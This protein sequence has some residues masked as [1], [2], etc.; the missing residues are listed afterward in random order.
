[1]NP[2]YCSIRRNILFGLLWLSGWI[3]ALILFITEKDIFT[4]EDKR[5]LLS[6]VICYGAMSLLSF[7][8]VV[9]IYALVC[10]IIACVYAFQHKSFKVPG[11]YQIAAAILK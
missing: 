7:T 10:S 6:I 5:E 1:M 4:L 8:F 3:P 9:P 2:I 11:V